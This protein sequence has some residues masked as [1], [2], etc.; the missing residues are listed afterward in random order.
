LHLAAP[1]HHH[2]ATDIAPLTDQS[3]AHHTPAP[4]RQ[5]GLRNLAGKPLSQHGIETILGNPFY[6]GLI[7]IK[8]TGA[9]YE[10]LHEPIVEAQVFQRV[11][12]VKAGKAGKKV[13]RH[14]HLYRGLF[15]CGLCNSPMSPERQKGQVYYRCQLSACPTR[16][17]R[18]DRLAN[19]IKAALANLELTGEQA[20]KLRRDWLS[21]TESD[22]RDECARSV[23]LRIDQADNRL[24]RLTDL[25]IDN[26]I[27]KEDFNE[28]KR[29]LKLELAGLDEQRQKTTRF[30][31]FG[32]QMEMFLELM[33]NLSGLYILAKPEEKR[34]MVENC[35][36]NRTVV[37]KELCLEPYSWLQ[38]RDFAELTP[39][40]NHNGPL[41]ELL[42]YGKIQSKPEDGTTCLPSPLVRKLDDRYEVKSYPRYES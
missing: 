19:E 39:M 28:R 2:G 14:N 4:S 35:L 24:S 8:R 5:I 30:H 12:D 11:Q 16:T 36:S 34:W 9:V 42:S 22:E 41:L 18:E 20:E 25:L 15:R 31:L 37:G 21:W 38:C 17:I 1:Y 13:T 3:A 6:T 7:V 33:K 27:T 29:V 10:G 23:D 40:V 32:R 26:T